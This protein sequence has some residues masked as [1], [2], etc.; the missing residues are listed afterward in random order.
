M[1]KPWLSNYPENVVHKVDLTRY[2]SLVDLFHQ[3][4]AKYQ[5]QSAYSNFGGELTFQQVAE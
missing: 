1:T 2:A 3:T 4:T 5:Q